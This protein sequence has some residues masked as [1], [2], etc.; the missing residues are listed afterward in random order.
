MDNNLW[1]NTTIRE[2]NYWSDFDEPSEGAYD[3][4]SDGIVDSPYYIPG[5][6]NV[7][8]YPLMHPTIIPSIV[9]VDDDFNSSTPG[10]GYDHFNK[11]QDGINAISNGNTVFVYSGLYEENLLINKS[12]RLIG[13]NF[14]TTII[15]GKG[16]GTAVHII[17]DSVYIDGFTVTN[18]KTGTSVG[19]Q[20]DSNYNK[21]TNCSIHHS[22]RGVIIS[23]HGGVGSIYNNISYC[24]IHNNTDSGIVLDGCT[25]TTVYSCEIENNFWG[26]E[27]RSSYNSIKNCDINNN[28][29]YGIYVYSQE[30]HIENCRIS[31]NKIGI[32]INGNYNRVTNCNVSASD[33]GIKIFQ[34]CNYNLLKD[35][36][37]Y[38]NSYGVEIVGWN[39][40]IM[41]CRFSNNGYGIKFYS[42]CRNNVTTCIFRNNGY[43][44]Y[45]H[46]TSNINCIY[47][48]Y[49]SNT[50]NAI[51][52]GINIWNISKTPSTNIIGGPYIAGNYWNDYNGIDT[53]GD[54]IGDTNLPYNCSGNIQQG[55]DYAPL[56]ES[57]VPPVANF[58]YLPLNPTTT[59]VIQF[60]DLSYD[61]DGS[62]VNWTW[63]FGDGNISYE[64]NPQHSYAD[65]GIYNVMLTVRDDDGAT[66]S[67]TK[68]IVVS[69]VPPVAANDTAITDEDTVVI[70]NISGNDY[71]T[72]GTLNLSSIVIINPTI[73]GNIIVNPNGTV[74]YTPNPNYYGYDEFNYTIEDDDGAISNV[75]NVFITILP[76]NDAP[77]ANDDFVSLNEDSYAIIDVLANDSDVED[78]IP[79]LNDIISQPSHGIA[80]INPNG[81]I[82]YEPDEN[83]YG[84]DSFVYEVIDSDGATDT[85]TVYI[86]ILPVNDPPVANDDYYTTDED[87]ALVVSAPGILAN[88]TD[89]D[90]DELHAILISNPSHGS[91]VLNENGSFVYTPDEDYNGMDGFT[92]VANDGSLNSNVATVYITILPVNDT[93]IANDDS[94]ATDEDNTLT[95]NAP[96]VLGNDYDADGDALTA[97]L[98]SNP[99]HGSLSFNS[100]G[101]F[102]YIPDV[103][104]YGTDSFTYKA[105]D[106]F[107]YSN[108]ATVTITILPI[109][110]A[111]VANFSWHPANPTDLDIVQF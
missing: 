98:V 50:I 8:R 91:L 26:I 89:V 5:G 42:T 62:I 23:M 16:D 39:N 60:T 94:Y 21:I 18:E 95:V 19:I 104:Y 83:Y 35:N 75:A 41:T 13:E 87:T 27:A 100:N 31:S 74:K 57:N 14:A 81:T 25:D 22:G 38:N 96:G 64:Q 52:N 58:S 15:R 24:R 109:N 92:Y 69:N 97:E 99:S 29:M 79:E 32:G 105:Y 66:D 72:D 80:T 10:W 2:G 12:I 73:H 86:S 78:G 43:G 71:D 76:V 108:I 46:S 85:A 70:I 45:M 93:P 54:G 9:Y 67:I 3:N 33:F 56:L 106:G 44:V 82:T 63:N 51:D 88:D 110:D 11:I 17:N 102:T 53:N 107:A 68:Q 20:I 101:S 111:P 37:L 47:N 34:S 55:G 1:Y 7:D 40:N 30:I 59:D 77:I 48:N 90:G 65:D 49:F 61:S 6:S 84:S 28:S 4:N 103:N 36:F